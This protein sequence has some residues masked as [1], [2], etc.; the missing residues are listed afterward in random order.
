MIRRIV[1][2]VLATVLLG[3]L[4]YALAFYAFEFK[5]KMIADIIMGSPQPP[6]T[7]SAEAVRTDTWQPTIP[8]I[9][10]LVA[11]EGI[12]LSPQVGGVVEYL[13]FDSGQDVKMGQLLVRLNSSTEEAEL[14]SI[15]V[16]FDNAETELARVEALAASGVAPKSQRDAARTTRDAFRAS[17]DRLEAVIAQKSV[18]APWDGKVGLR[19]ISLG[20]Y[21]SPGQKIVWLQ[22][23]DP[24]FADFQIT[25]TD[26]ARIKDGLKVVASFNAYPGEQ[27]DGTIATTDARVSDASRMLTVRAT[28]ANPS[29]RL[30]P[31]MYAAITVEAGAPEKVVTVPETSVTYSL[32]GDNVFVVVPATRLD[33]SAKPGEL[34]IERRFVKAGGMRDGRVQIVSGLAEGEQ[35]V[36][37]GQNKID[38]GS[39]VLIDNSVALKPQDTTTIQ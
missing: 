4:G 36:T 3:G 30:L 26:Y 29:G 15:K 19:T 2:F 35:V 16:Q 20:S 27:F 13:G 28:I 31:G 8:G 25:E 14:R 32:Y 18:Y 21:L 6:Q 22:K 39:K 34:A 24:V 1:Y 37:A 9:G 5:P 12:D 38:Q 7:I 33:P 11:S 23:I 17:L 10:T